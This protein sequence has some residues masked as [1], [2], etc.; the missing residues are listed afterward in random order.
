[1]KVLWGVLIVAIVLLQFR[2]WTGEGSFAQVW[3]LRE[4]IAQQQEANANLASRN[5]EL[6]AEVGNLS[7]GKRAVEERARTNLGLVREG[8]TFFLVAD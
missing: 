2:L 6:L 4:Q 5:S 8:E 3:Q 1:M 7:D